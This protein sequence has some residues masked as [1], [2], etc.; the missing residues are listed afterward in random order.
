M[1]S[2]KRQRQLARAKAERQA[3]RR[4]QRD[5]SRR[6]RTRIIGAA[7]VAVAVVGALGFTLRSNSDT[8]PAADAVPTQ[9][10]TPTESASPD[11]PEVPTPGPVPAPKGVS[12]E[13]AAEQ[14]PGG[15]PWKKPADVGVSGSSEWVVR[16]N[17]GAITIAVDGR[18]APENVNALA[19]LTQEGFFQGKNCHRL[20]TAGIY[21]LQCGS[22][23]LD[24]TGEVGFTLPDENLPESGDDNYPTGTV[25]MA[26]SGPDT[27]SSQFFI[28]YK[29]S[30]LPPGYSIVGEVTQGL[31]VVKYVASQGVA[32]GSA[33]ASDGAPSQTVVISDAGVEG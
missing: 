30:T 1:N 9:A 3:A 26:N 33:D 18:T 14:Q 19:F 11:A 29:D 8:A 10:A 17:C 12:C 31:D 7:I 24:G 4:A 23:N 21:V 6:R 2:N 22:P 15:G 27:A 20:T 16:T 13:K 28:V 25:A 32:S 5:R